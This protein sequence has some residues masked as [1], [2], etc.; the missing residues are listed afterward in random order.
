MTD[1]TPPHATQLAAHAILQSRDIVE[2]TP[3][4]ALIDDPEWYARQM[5]LTEADRAHMEHLP[6]TGSDA[7]AMALYDHARTLA[8]EDAGMIDPTEGVDAPGDAVI[9]VDHATGP[10]R[11][12]I[13]VTEAGVTH[14]PYVPIPLLKGRETPPIRLLAKK[15]RALTSDD[16]VAKA[17]R[18]IMEQTGVNALDG[19]LVPL[20]GSGLSSGEHEK[21]IVRAAVRDAITDALRGIPDDD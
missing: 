5:G 13:V 3:P 18:Q 7:A 14:E 6:P 16:A 11:T 8:R 4:E 9:G 17:L 20:C 19:L 12:A 21:A 2:G 1:R 15:I 10:E